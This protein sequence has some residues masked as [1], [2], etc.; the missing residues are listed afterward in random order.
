MDFN[1]S[2]NVL[3][4][5]LLALILLSSLPTASASIG[6]RSVYY[7]RCKHN[8]SLDNCTNGSLDN[9]NSRQPLYMKLMGWD[10]PEE[11]S[12]GCMWA[13]VELFSNRNVRVPQFHGKWPFIRILG[14]Q[15]PASVLFSFLNGLMHIIGIIEYRRRLPSDAPMYWI[16]HAFAAVGVNTWFWSTVF[17][18]RDVLLTERMDYFC[19]A[20]LLLMNIFTLAVRSIG[21]HQGKCRRD[22]CLVFA[23][24]LLSLFVCHV[25]YLTFYK[26]DYGYNMAASVLAGAVNSVWM[27]IWS[28]KNWDIHGGIKKA[29]VITVSVNFLISLELL[30]FSPIFWMFDA[31]SLWHA[32]TIL[33]TLWWYSYII[34]DSMYLYKVKERY[35]KIE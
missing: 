21:Y 8:C 34:E 14:V 31:H 30:D 4:F 16:W 7:N 15:E 27:L 32:S 26:F 23:A 6:D 29:L 10:C 28:V 2:G 20:S 3:K 11:C 24:V 22:I 18:S 35:F 25:S 19:A 1:S 17:H 33:P 9:F 5:C 12:Y 13:T